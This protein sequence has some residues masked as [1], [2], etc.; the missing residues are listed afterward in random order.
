MSL[1]LNCTFLTF[2]A[3]LFSFSNCSNDS[4]RASSKTANNPN[5][6]IIGKWQNSSDENDLIAEEITEYFEN[7]ELATMGSFTHK[8][9][10]HVNC[11]YICKGS[12]GVSG[13]TLSIETITAEVKC[14]VKQMENEIKN[15]LE[16]NDKTHDIIELNE[17]VLI[18]RIRDEKKAEV[19]YFR[20]KE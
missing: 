20:V 5:K 18:I 1:L 11:K 13:K 16:E 17:N 7:G 10:A 19:T 4:V 15:D 14:G 9:Q 8:V 12:Y 2:L 6:L 3:I